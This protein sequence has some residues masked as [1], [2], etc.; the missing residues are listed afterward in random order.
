MLRVVVPAKHLR[1]CSSSIQTDYRGETERKMLN[2]LMA[3]QAKGGDL[4]F[5]DHNGATPLHVASANGYLSVV[6]FLLVSMA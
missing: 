3:I 1:K 4:E 6:E 2:D 5:R